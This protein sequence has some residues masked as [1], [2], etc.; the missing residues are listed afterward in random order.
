LASPRSGRCRMEYSKSDGTTY[1]TIFS[2]TRS[3][4]QF[5]PP[6]S[7]LPHPQVKGLFFYRPFHHVKS[8]TST[9]GSVMLCAR[10][11]ATPFFPVPA[12]FELETVWAAFSDVGTFSLFFCFHRPP[13]VL[14]AP[15]FPSSP[16]FPSLIE[17]SF[18]P[19]ES[20]E[21]PPPRSPLRGFPSL[22]G[23]SSVF[24]VSC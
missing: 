14:G 20:L 6:P 18:P 12:T 21:F 19:P 3:I 2:F 5:R 24:F 7:F 13:S 4:R 22:R 8:W 11:L 9:P 10:P 16:L 23:R 17:A 1:V 15:T